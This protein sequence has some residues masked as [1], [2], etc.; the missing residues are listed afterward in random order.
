MEGQSS[1]TKQMGLA[2][3]LISMPQEALMEVNV[4]ISN[5]HLVVGLVLVM[6]I[7]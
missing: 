5:T 4:T 2:V 1:I 3:A 6:G 7:D